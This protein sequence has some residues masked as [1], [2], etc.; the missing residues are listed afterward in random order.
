MSWVKIG[1]IWKV[2]DPR[3]EQ[4]EVNGGELFRSVQWCEECSE[5]RRVGIITVP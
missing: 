5:E 4:G 1:A 2:N 3:G